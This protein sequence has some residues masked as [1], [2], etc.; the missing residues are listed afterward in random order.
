M[1]VCVFVLF[2]INVLHNN[3]IIIIDN[4]NNIINIDLCGVYHKVRVR[5][6]FLCWQ[7]W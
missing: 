6:D 1:I 4:S 5:S 3:I 7:F 2:L